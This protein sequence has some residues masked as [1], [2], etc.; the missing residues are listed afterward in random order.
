MNDQV[1][2]LGEKLT[3][4]QATKALR[5]VIKRDLHPD[6]TPLFYANTAAADKAR[7]GAASEHDAAFKL[8]HFCSIPS[9]ISTFS[10]N[11]YFSYFYTTL[12]GNLNILISI[13]IKNKI[14]RL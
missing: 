7:A 2:F 14:H 1:M 10:L 6:R 12:F 5:S 4:R 11:C 13:K 3:R 8:K 9:S